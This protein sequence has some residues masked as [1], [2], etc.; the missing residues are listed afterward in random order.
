[1]YLDTLCHFIGALGSILC[2]EGCCSLY[3]S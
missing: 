1:M 3:Y 2:P